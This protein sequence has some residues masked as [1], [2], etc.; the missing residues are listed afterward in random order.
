[1]A[2]KRGVYLELTARKNHRASNK[3]LFKLAR[4]IGANLILNTDAH[5]EDDL[6]SDSKA[7]RILKTIGLNES[8]I[9]AVFKN[10]RDLIKRPQSRLRIKKSILP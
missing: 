6:V 1:M 5:S 2:K 9:K 10:S 7:R 3:R 8:E 4:P